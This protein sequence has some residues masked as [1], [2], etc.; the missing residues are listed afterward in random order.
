M[1][2]NQFNNMFNLGEFYKAFGA[3]NANLNKAASAMRENAKACGVAAKTASDGWQNIANCLATWGQRQ[4][5]ETSKFFSSFASAKSPETAF[6]QIAKAAQQS[7]NSAVLSARE[8]FKVASESS[9]EAAEVIA[10][11]ASAALAELNSSVSEA[12]AASSSEKSNKKN[13]A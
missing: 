8:I 9:T 7:A 2:N 6:E 5:E 3:D 13:A 10:K 11:R 1:S 4:A 12:G